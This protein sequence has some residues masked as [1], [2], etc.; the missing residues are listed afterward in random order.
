M[1]RKLM[2]QARAAAVL[3]WL[4]QE[5]GATTSYNEPVTPRTPRYKGSTTLYGWNLAI[6][7]KPDSVLDAD[8]KPT[9]V[10]IVRAWTHK[11]GD[12]VTSRS[13]AKDDNGVQ[14]PVRYMV[15]PDHSLRRI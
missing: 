7:P 1:K 11:P 9:Q 4:L 2:A 12:I 15:R 10:E 13:F 3:A 8:G 6:V 14:W 5:L